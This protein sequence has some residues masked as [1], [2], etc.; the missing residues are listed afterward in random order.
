MENFD[1]VN[2]IISC[3]VDKAKNDNNI[4]EH[5]AESIH[6][7]CKST[8]TFSEFLPSFVRKKEYSGCSW[9]GL[10]CNCCQHNG[11]LKCKYCVCNK[12]GISSNVTNM[13]PIF[14]GYCFDCAMKIYG[15]NLWE[16]YDCPE[17]PA[18]F[19]SFEYALP[20]L[21]STSN[22]H[23]KHHYKAIIN[24]TLTCKAFYKYNKQI[25]PVER[26]EK[27]LCKI[28]HINKK[29]THKK[30]YDCHIRCYYCVRFNKI[31][32]AHRTCHYC[33]GY[34]KYYSN[35]CVKCSDYMHYN[36]CNRNKYGV[37]YK[38]DPEFFDRQTTCLYHFYPP[39]IYAPVIYTPL[40]LTPVHT[41]YEF[42]NGKLCSIN[43]TVTDNKKSN[44]QIL[45][46]IFPQNKSKKYTFEDTK[47]NTQKYSNTHFSKYNNRNMKQRRI[48]QP[49]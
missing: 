27:C 18:R 33:G 47:K 21:V 44:E 23:C 13:A 34:T 11:T 32:C 26:Y 28:K 2:N 5:F 38:R 17:I 8:K 6:N 24:L 48:N 22:D 46:L 41:W 43:S 45:S 12:C 30:C 31:R 42:K 25:T 10:V 20:A 9:C 19:R 3:L 36:K 16:L 4:C 37:S 40:I 35:M 7:L 29:Y 49:R 39:V 14:K 1:K 15:Y